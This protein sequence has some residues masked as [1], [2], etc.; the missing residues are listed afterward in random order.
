[1]RLHAVKALFKLINNYNIYFLEIFVNNYLFRI[2]VAL[3]LSACLFVTSGCDSTVPRPITE[4]PVILNISSL[5]ELHSLLNKLDYTAENWNTA[6]RD[7]PHI[8]FEGISKGWVTH[9]AKLPVK[10]KKSLFFRLITPLSL[11]SNE[12]ILAERL[13]VESASLSATELLNIAIKYKIIKDIHAP[14][15]KKLRELLLIR[16]DI[17]PVSLVLAQS[18]EESGWGTSRFAYEGNALFGQWDF[19]G[20]GMKPK[21]QRKA[22][23]NYGIARFDSP[24]QSVEAYMF[25]INT[26]VAYNKLRALRATMRGNNSQ[27]SGYELATTLNKYSERGDAYIQGIRQL[28]SYNELEATDSAKLQHDKWIHLTPSIQ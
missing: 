28:I 9:S 21:Q 17:I 23:G 26:N 5:D 20:N 12:R 3:V 7:I 24:L 13:I 27:L 11:I 15:T 14:L 16:V 10:T 6:D 2:T 4:Q 25:N 1:M 19:S 22:L 8:T 18:A